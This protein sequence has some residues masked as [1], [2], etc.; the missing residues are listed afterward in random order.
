MLALFP[1]VLFSVSLA[2][3][4][5]G[6]VGAEP[7]IELI[8]GVWPEE[9]AGPLVQE[10]RAVIAEGDSG[11]MTLGGILAIW[12]ASNGADAVRVALSRAYRDDDPRPF[13]QTR[14]L[15]LVFVVCGGAILLSGAALGLAL[16]TVLALFGSM[17]P[18]QL[19]ELSDYS[20]LAPWLTLALVGFGVF[21]A[22]IWMPGL[23]HSFSEV[24]PGVVLTLVTWSAAILGF[25]FYLGTVANYSATY[26]G[27]A[28]AMAALI[29]L[30]LL[31][32]ILILGAE[33]NGA[34]L[35]QNQSATV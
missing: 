35:D 8:F 10:I 16:P 9:I 12:F 26:A 27:L 2:S 15:S 34:R 5:T 18:S 29:F 17:V 13:W 3:S 7:M 21:A 6:E 23:R 32:A 11:L 19:V 25:S 28:G 33:F 4:L 1:F 14:A 22:H 24:W 31:A 30:Y 20:A